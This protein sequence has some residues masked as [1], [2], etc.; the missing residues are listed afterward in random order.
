MKN[1]IFLAIFLLYMLT[2]GNVYALENGV[3][4]PLVADRMTD[5]G[6][7]GAILNAQVIVTNGTGHVFIDTSPYT[8]VDLQGSTRIAAM[9]ASD[10]LGIDQKLYDFYYIIEIDS[11]IIGGPS[12]G[13]ALTVATIAAINNWQIKPGVV[14]TGTI[15]PDEAIGPVGGIP[16]KLEAAATKN[17]TLFLIPQG[18]LIVNTTNVTMTGIGIVNHSTDTV[19][20]NKLG[21][22]LGI[23]VKE[24]S[25]IQD[26]VL[27]FTGHDISKK[28]TNKTVFTTDYLNLLE[29]LALQLANESKNMYNNT[30]FIDND[31]IKNA[32]NLQNQADNLTNNK[33]YYAATSLYFQSMVNMLASQWEY[34][35][36]HEKDQDEYII[37]LMN[38]VQTQIQS[39]ENNLDKFKSQGI[40]D[41]EVIGA[42]E[43]RIME[44]HDILENVKNSDGNVKDIIPRLAFANERARSA[45]W[46]LT[47]FVPSGKTIPEDILR[48]RSGWYLSQA[49]SISTYTQSLI[50]GYSNVIIDKDDITFVQ[51][52][53][54]RGYYSGAIFDSLRIISSSSTGI[55][56][57]AVQDPSA[58]INQSAKAAEIAI[59][60]ARSEGIEPTLAVSAYEYGEI[61]TNPFAKISQYSY[62]K[63][64]AKTTE[65]LY[66]RALKSNETIKPDITIPTV[67]RS[68]TPITDK[69]SPA[70]EAIILII[71]ILMIRRLKN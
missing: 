59:N 10:V 28:S 49:Q 57:L 65:S 66:S 31:L 50:P 16:T 53:I 48:E 69:K 32:L 11:P 42:A 70:F 40:S 15:D 54:S 39:S 5:N 41:V 63:M 13:G 2:I 67:N 14:M 18:Q 29:P 34:Q 9:V 58:R 30:A 68:I 56:L 36:D 17:T 43:S 38:T 19:D 21:E 8:Q 51:K 25:T 26:A 12:A 44:A 37:N 35:Y 1:K 45:Q 24:V 62:A 61:L 3:I 7:E 6:E 23:T 27:E 64:V 60:E 47:F 4:I 55:K 22:K 71:I 52:E 33:K 46:W 20:L